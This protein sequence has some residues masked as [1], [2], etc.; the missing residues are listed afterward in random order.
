MSSPESVSIIQ[1]GIVASNGLERTATS[2]IIP[3]TTTIEEWQMI[4][5]SFRRADDILSWYVGDWLAFGERHKQWKDQFDAAVDFIGIEPSTLHNYMYVSRHISSSR[6]REDVSWSHHYEVAALD[7]ESQSVWLDQTERH[8]LSV[9]ELRMSIKAGRVLRHADIAAAATSKRGLYSPQAVHSLFMR[10][11]RQT[12]TRVP[13]DQWTP[14]MQDAW[15]EE[16]EPIIDLA[17]KL[18]AARAARR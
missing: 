3:E 12:C 16:L 15:L 17:S 4:G 18:T 2:L 7:D 5:V 9:R 10:A 13:L 14:T 6:R 8:N 1:N 11:Y